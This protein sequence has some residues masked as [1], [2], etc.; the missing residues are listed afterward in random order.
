M[1]EPTVTI[2]G[3]VVADAQEHVGASGRPF[4]VF[5][6]ANT[7]QRRRPDG[8]YEDVRTEYYRVTAFGNLAVNTA[9]SIRKGQR[10][11]VHGKVRATTYTRSDGSEGAS[12][13]IT[14]S[15]VGHD[16][17]FGWADYHKGRRDR[18]DPADPQNDPAVRAARA[19]EGQRTQDESD[20]AHSSQQW[21]RHPG[22]EQWNPDYVA[23]YDADPF[24]PADS[25]NPL[26]D[27][28]QDG[29]QDVPFAGAEDTQDTED[30]EGQAS[31]EPE[32]A[33]V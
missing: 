11:L 1:N 15:M 31:W 26:S 7:I 13:E 18:E 25:A 30:E 28:G 5:R 6:L 29:D 2:S 3:N 27:G 22:P 14:A 10:V 4:T 9:H 19:G 32:P 17:T 21:G 8:G 23:A 20:P 33:T 16:L 24:G 12:I